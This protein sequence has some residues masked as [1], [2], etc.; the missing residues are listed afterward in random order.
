MESITKNG[1]THFICKRGLQVFP[2]K[3]AAGW[4]MGTRDVDGYPNCRIT[5]EYAE[6]REECLKLVLNRQIGCMENEFCN[7]GKG[8]FDV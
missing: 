6:T 1:E 3:S 8:C 4:Y 5:R 7:G 2:M